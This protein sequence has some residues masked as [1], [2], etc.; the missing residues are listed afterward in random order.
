MDKIGSFSYIEMMMK[1][2]VKWIVFLGFVI[3]SG[4]TM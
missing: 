1:E 3:G 2:C 4:D